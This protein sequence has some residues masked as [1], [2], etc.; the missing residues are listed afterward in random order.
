M[1]T[2][3]PDTPPNE[4]TVGVDDAGA[5]LTG[6]IG[7]ADA[8]PL[9]SGIVGQIF[10]DAPIEDLTFVDDTIDNRE[11][12]VILEDRRG[13]GFDRDVYDVVNDDLA[14]TL[15]GVAAALDDHPDATIVL[16][17]HA[18]TAG[19]DEADRAAA[20]R[21]ADTARD[22][23]IEF[24]IDETRLGTLGAGEDGTFPTT[25]ETS[26]NRRIDYLID[27]LSTD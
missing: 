2:S 16:I 9:I 10:P 24:G 18:I 7:A 26:I 8:V 23:L 20:I 13:V 22:Y 12:T 25:S 21:R 4:V 3:A 6:L 27:G 5:E 1:A 15:D 14:E 11:L 19:D 17:G